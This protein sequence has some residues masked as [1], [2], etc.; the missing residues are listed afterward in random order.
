MPSLLT[1]DAL[2][3]S[4]ATISS[5]STTRS[6]FALALHAF[7]LCVFLVVVVALLLVPVA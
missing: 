3:T 4:T 5:T 1:E 7:N 2:T 6:L